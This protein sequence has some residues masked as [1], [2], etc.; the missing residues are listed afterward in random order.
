MEISHSP[1]DACE[2]ISS[3]FFF[4]VP[5]SKHK[6]LAIYLLIG[7]CFPMA[8]LGQFWSNH[9]LPLLCGLHVFCR[10]HSCVLFPNKLGVHVFFKY[11]YF[12]FLCIKSNQPISLAFSIV[13]VVWAN[14]NPLLIRIQGTHFKLLMWFCWRL[15]PSTCDERQASL[16]LIFWEDDIQKTLITLFKNILNPQ[17]FIKL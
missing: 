10:I 2:C 11:N 13:W 12:S 17:S 5:S 3:D 7:G 6:N 1:P 16:L 8:C 9:M 14:I 4:M 15:F